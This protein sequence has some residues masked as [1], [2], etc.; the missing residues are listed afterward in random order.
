MIGG[1]FIAIIISPLRGWFVIGGMFIAQYRLEAEATVR[2]TAHSPFA[3]R[4][5]RI[6]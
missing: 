4:D 2:G 6:K 3:R 5:L 1:M